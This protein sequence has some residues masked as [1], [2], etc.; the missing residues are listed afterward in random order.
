MYWNVKAISIFNF[1]WMIQNHL[2]F[3]Y[4]DLINLLHYF[5]LTNCVIE[6]IEMCIKLFWNLMFWFRGICELFSFFCI[7]SLECGG[8]NCDLC[9]PKRREWMLKEEVLFRA[10]WLCFRWGLKNKKY[11]FWK[12]VC[13][14]EIKFRPLHSETTGNGLRD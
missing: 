7:K 1:L 13:F 3:L 9:T 4:S 5:K 10:Y 8:K 2:V 12:R 14:L 6:N 11:F